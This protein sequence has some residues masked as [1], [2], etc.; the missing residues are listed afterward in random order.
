MSGCA[1]CTQGRD[2]ARCR[3]PDFGD[4]DA[5]VA[6]GDVSSSGEDV[7]PG[8]RMA[9]GQTIHARS[10]NPK[11]K[12][13]KKTLIFRH[14]LVHSALFSRF[15]DVLRRGDVS[16]S[17]EGV[18]PGDRLAR[19]ADHHCQVSAPALLAQGRLVRAC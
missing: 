6:R 10:G 14:T 2:D 5:L 7:A 16:S 1:R 8:D 17:G 4:L 13:P 18:A 3:L 15:H 9:R 12:N 19:R 11:P